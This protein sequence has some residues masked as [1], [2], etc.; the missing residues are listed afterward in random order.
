MNINEAL[1]TIDKDKSY[2]I[3]EKTELS[4]LNEDCKNKPY[5]A[6]VDVETTGLNSKEDEIISLSYLKIYYEDDGKTILGIS[7]P[8]TFFNQPSIP[9]SEEI[10]RLT[11]IT[12]EMVDGKHIDFQ[13]I[14]N[15]FLD[16]DINIAH[17][18][19]FDR[20]FMEK[21]M[22]CLKHTKW[23]CSCNDIDWKKQD[24]NGKGLEFIA[25]KY[26]LFYDAHQSENDVI[27]IATIIAKK[28]NFL[29]DIIAKS[30]E[31]SYIIVA[32]NLPFAR[33]DAFKNLGGKWLPENK[34]WYLKVGKDDYD[35]VKQKVFKLYNSS[36]V[37]P[38][39]VE[40]VILD[41]LDKHSKRISGDVLCKTFEVKKNKLEF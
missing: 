14:E 38:K 9:I 24:I 13:S 22:P 36:R 7:R 6:V 40:T 15:I 29:K 34:V 20:A 33:K 28:N 26:N 35:N 25:F 32:N 16:A 37:N 1:K 12:N 23:G 11:G 31:P 27:A 2:K 4:F 30:N 5:A 8:K 3:L 41:N 19:E 17:N 10:T 39:D 21:Y 18:A